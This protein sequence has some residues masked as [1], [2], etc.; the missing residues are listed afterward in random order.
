MFTKRIFAVVF[1][2]CLGIIFVM[3]GCKF[4]PLTPTTYSITATAGEGGQIN[5]EGELAISEGGNQTFTITPDEGYQINDVLVDDESVG[6]VGEYTFQDVQ[7]DHT[8]DAKAATVLEIL[9]IEGRK[10]LILNTGKRVHIEKTPIY[11]KNNTE[12]NKIELVLVYQ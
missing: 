9:S 2:L 10:E 12:V 8:I 4:T 7:Q 3:G 6:A 1:V 11:L 5:P